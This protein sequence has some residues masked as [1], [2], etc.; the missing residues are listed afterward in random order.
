MCAGVYVPV[1]VHM[2]AFGVCMCVCMYVCMYLHYNS[3]YSGLHSPSQK[4]EDFI[5][6]MAEAG[7]HTSNLI[8][9]GT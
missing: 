8:I 4:S 2:H 5:Y 6:T 1:N 9:S 7:N 3:I